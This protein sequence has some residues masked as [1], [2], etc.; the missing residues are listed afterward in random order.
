MGISITGIVVYRALY[1][2]MFDNAKATF[3][4]DANVLMKWTTAQLITLAAS[5]L[6]YPLDTVRARLMM[7][8]GRPAEDVIYKG[9]LDCFKV[10]LR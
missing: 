8:S 10:I 6:T 1:F 9:T 4:K 3:L 2:G 7:Q 5:F